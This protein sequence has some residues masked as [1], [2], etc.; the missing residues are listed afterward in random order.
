ML[1]LIRE[2]TVYFGSLARMRR[3]DLCSQN[4]TTLSVN[5]VVQRDIE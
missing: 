5:V 1:G 2:A 3:G 4:N